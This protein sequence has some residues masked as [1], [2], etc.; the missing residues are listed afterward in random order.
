[1]FHAEWGRAAAWDSR[2]HLL[3][4]NVGFTAETV[5]S[6]TS[7]HCILAYPLYAVVER[8]ITLPRISRRTPV[9][10][11]TEKDRMVRSVHVPR[12]GAVV[13]GVGDGVGVGGGVTMMPDPGPIVR[14]RR[15][16]TVCV[17]AT[18]T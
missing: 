12:G 14:V 16:G 11:L 10:S 9:S 13:V 18:D 15:K 1:M 3:P 5:I 17:A 8:F 4:T 7:T 6:R 2:K